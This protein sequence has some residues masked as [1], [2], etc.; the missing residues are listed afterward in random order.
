MRRTN[1]GLTRSNQA[2][3]YCDDTEEY[4]NVFDDLQET[5]ISSALIKVLGYILTIARRCFLTLMLKIGA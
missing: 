4:R 2:Y 3:E 5:I 1:K